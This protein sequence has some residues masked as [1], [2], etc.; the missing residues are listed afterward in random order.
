MPM[1]KL[2]TSVTT[3]I[4]Y[5]SKNLTVILRTPLTRTSR[6]RF[7]ALT[8]DMY[9][10]IAFEIGHF[11]IGFQPCSLPYDKTS[12]HLSSE[13][14]IDGCKSEMDRNL[15]SS[16]KYIQGTLELWIE[17]YKVILCIC[18]FRQLCILRP[19]FQIA[20]QAKLWGFGVSIFG[21]HDILTV[22]YSRPS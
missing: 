11:R 17:V 16:G 4:F 1:S 20:K 13:V 14:K 7:K 3:V 9:D 19:A 8:S 2:Q 22:K 15:E 18:N 12:L 21:V 5:I 6:K 10:Y